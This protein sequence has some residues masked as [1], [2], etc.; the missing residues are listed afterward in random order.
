M[1]SPIYTAPV[2]QS[3]VDMADVLRKKKL[4]EMLLQ[5]GAQ[6]PQGGGMVGRT[7][8]PISPLAA[9]APLVQTGAGLYA[10]KQADKQAGDVGARQQQLLGQWL[11]NQPQS[12][13]L[14]PV[15]PTGGFKDPANQQGYNLAQQATT[16]EFNRRKLGWALQGQQLGGMGEA[17]GGKVAADALKTPDPYTLSPGATRFDGSGNMIASSPK[18]ASAGVQ[19]Q[20]P[21]LQAYEV[22]KSQGYNK[23]LLDFQ[24]ELSNAQ[25]NYPYTV[26]TINGVATLVDRTTG[27]PVQN[28]GA[29]GPSAAPPAAPSVQPPPAPSAPRTI[30]LTTLPQE[31]GA[32]GEIAR[33]KAEGG[34]LGEAQGKIAGGIQTKGANAQTVNSMLDEATALIPKSTGSRIGSGVDTVESWFGSTNEGAKSVAQLKVI[35]AG[36]MANMPR[37]EGPQSDRDVLLYQQAAGQLGDPN[38][39]NEI[40]QAAV[41]TIR[42]IQNRYASRAVGAAAPAAVGVPQ[43][44]P[45]AAPMQIKSDSD[46]ESL[47]SGSEFIAP[48]GSHRRKP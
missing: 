4:A 11:Q 28:G 6:G 48:D 22:A 32:Q 9:L 16:D 14:Q 46:Y 30:P 26:A 34:A 19:R 1:S 12:D 39:P 23:S 41:A 38:V 36:L 8:A 33:T 43:I 27:Q 29:P 31:A 10:D 2:P 13:E 21:L 44:A 18:S 40:K 45:S 3:N 35:E 25:A 5:M 17:I 24:K 47:P 37:M 20:S 15:M 7:V 42:N